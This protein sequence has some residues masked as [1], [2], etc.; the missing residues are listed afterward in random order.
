[1]GSLIVVAVAGPPPASVA[2]GVATRHVFGIVTEWDV[3][4]SVGALRK[5]TLGVSAVM[6]LHVNMISSNGTVG[7]AMAMMTR[8]DDPPRD[9][10]AIGSPTVPSLDIILTCGLWTADT[11][12]ELALHYNEEDA[13]D[14]AKLEREVGRR[15]SAR[16]T[17]RKLPEQ[18]FIYPAPRAAM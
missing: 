11:S 8:G 2:S 14:I 10:A 3:L 6:T 17:C 4:E 16:E 7:E 5:G 12:R 15:C 9:I 13:R 1:M 18:T